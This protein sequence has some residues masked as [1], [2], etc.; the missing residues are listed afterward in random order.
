MTTSTTRGTGM[1]TL[2]QKIDAAA[3]QTLKP[4][5]MVT[6]LASARNVFY[7]YGYVREVYTGRWRGQDGTRLALVFWPPLKRA[8]MAATVEFPVDRLEKIGKTHPSYRDYWQ[9]NA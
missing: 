5:E 2:Q 9:W 1:K 6:E 3:R 4:G 7:A 8:G